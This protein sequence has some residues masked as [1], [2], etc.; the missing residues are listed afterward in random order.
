MLEMYCEL[1]N[2]TMTVFKVEET[3]N[4]L[5]L[6]E[7]KDKKL[8]LDHRSKNKIQTYIKFFSDLFSY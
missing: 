1:K 3:K 6:K 4:K 7:S 2:Y 8:E 5:E